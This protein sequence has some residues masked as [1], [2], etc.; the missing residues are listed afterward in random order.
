MLDV[1]CILFAEELLKAYPEA[2]IILTQR[3]VEGELLIPYLYS[4]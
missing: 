4:I 1:P 2:K 3:P